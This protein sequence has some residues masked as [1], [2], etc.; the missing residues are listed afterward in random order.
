MTDIYIYGT[1][2]FIFSLFLPVVIISSIAESKEMGSMW[3]IVSV[4]IAII[5]WIALGVLL[6]GR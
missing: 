3:P 4:V 2:Y 6:F 1:I 5:I